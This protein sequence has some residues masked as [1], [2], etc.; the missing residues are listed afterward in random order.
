MGEDPSNVNY[1]R[2]TPDDVWA[3]VEQVRSWLVDPNR[4]GIPT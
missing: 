4:K 1:V 3:F 2:P